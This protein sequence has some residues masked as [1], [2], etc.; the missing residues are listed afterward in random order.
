V[1][2]NYDLALM[3]AAALMVPVV[4]ISLTLPRFENA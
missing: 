3:I 2:G 4:I 1:T